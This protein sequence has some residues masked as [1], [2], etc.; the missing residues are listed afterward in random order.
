ME[1]KTVE[2]VTDAAINLAHLTDEASKAKVFIESALK[3]GK[4]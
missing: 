2:N 1:T 4:L 3:D